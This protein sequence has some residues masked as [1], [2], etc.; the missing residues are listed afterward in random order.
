MLIQHFH[1]KIFTALNQYL[2]SN[3][4]GIDSMCLLHF[5]NQGA[6]THEFHLAGQDTRAGRQLMVVVSQHGA[7]TNKFIKGTRIV[8][9]SHQTN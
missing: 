2:D 3:N 8:K 4:K 7:G 5:T 6:W 9:N 1:F